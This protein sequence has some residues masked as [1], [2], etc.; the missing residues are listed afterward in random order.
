MSEHASDQ[1]HRAFC[2]V[3]AQLVIA[4]G[5]VT[6]AERAFLERVMDRFGLDDAARQA[7]INAVD[8]DDPIGPRLALLGPDARRALL[9]ELEVAA[10]VDGEINRSELEIIQEVRRA[11]E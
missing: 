9:A 4:D 7:V 3:I 11:L 2:E 8:I 10:A 6:D 1:E 5:A